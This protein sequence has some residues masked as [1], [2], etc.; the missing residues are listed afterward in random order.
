[1]EKLPFYA[2]HAV[3]EV[4]VVDSEGEAARILVRAGGRHAEAPASRL[5]GV[6][7]AGP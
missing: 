7:S 1:M 2:E 5:L 6:T 4:V 3:D